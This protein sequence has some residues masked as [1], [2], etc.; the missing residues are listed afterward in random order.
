MESP[1]NMT[2]MGEVMDA[3][4]RVANVLLGNRG[5]T[6]CDSCLAK[7]LA[8]DGRHEVQQVTSALAD[9]SLFQRRFGTCSMC[10]RDRLVIVSN[11]AA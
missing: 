2:D 8:F 9:S 5:N 7:S 11:G 10:R 6:Y 3:M 4:D 1:S